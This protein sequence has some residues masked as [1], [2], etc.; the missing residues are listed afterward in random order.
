MDTRCASFILLQ[1]NT[2]KTIYILLLDEGLDVWRPTTG[3]EIGENIYKVEP[4]D[5]YDDQDEKWEFKPGSTV[6]CEYKNLSEGKHLVAVEEI[7]NSF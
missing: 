6:R 1:M 5:D 7:Q 2:K 3:L 4:T